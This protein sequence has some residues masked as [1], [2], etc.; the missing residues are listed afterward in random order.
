[1]SFDW[2]EFLNFAE[3]IS[4]NDLPSYNRSGISRA[5]YAVFG[6]ARLFC[7]AENLIRQSDLKS[8]KIH[9]IVVDALKDSD[10]EFLFEIGARIEA[11]KN[12]RKEADYE[13]FSRDVSNK[14]L[15]DTIKKS[16]EVLDLISEYTN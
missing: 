14:H 11:L 10:D 2:R 5:Y 8:Y 16:H 4:S 15:L 12:R 13:A 1:M 6:Y 7:V 3:S 9:A